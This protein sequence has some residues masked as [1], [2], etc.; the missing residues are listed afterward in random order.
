MA[1]YVKYRHKHPNSWTP[2]SNLKYYRRTNRRVLYLQRS[3]GSSVI[4]QGYMNDCT[5]SCM[6]LSLFLSYRAYSIVWRLLNTNANYTTGRVAQWIRI[7]FTKNTHAHKQSSARKY[8]YTYIER[9]HEETQA[10]TATSHLRRRRCA[11]G[12]FFTE[13]S[14]GRRTGLS[15]DGRALPCPATSAEAAAAA[16]LFARTAFIPARQQA[17]ER[18]RG[19]G[20]EVG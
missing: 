10:N 6:C 2:Y 8:I 20:A 17:A 3:F 13:D 7:G 15:S 1:F 16:I 11:S 18:R 4:V 12:S 9:Q 5:G 14:S 19:A